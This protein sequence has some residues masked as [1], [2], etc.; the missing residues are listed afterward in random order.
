VR[1]RIA[2]F[3]CPRSVEFRPLPKLS[4]GKIQKLVL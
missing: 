4:T 3:K 2:R 1:G